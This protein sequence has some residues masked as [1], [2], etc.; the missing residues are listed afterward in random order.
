MSTPMKIERIDRLS[1]RD[2]LESF[3]K[4]GRPVVL[5]GLVEQW[6]VAKWDLSYLRG[7]LGQTPMRYERWEGA[8][9]DPTD[10]LRKTNM[11]R[12]NQMPFADLVDL[13]ERP[14]A[15]TERPYLT[16]YDI[17]K[18]HPGLR[19]DVSPL[20]DWMVGPG[21]LPASLKE[22][23]R[24]GPLLWLGPEGTLSPV[25]FDMLW[26]LFVQVRG[27][28]RF[29]L[30][31]P[32]DAGNLYYPH[33]PFEWAVHFSPVD[34]ESPDLARHPRFSQATPMEVE[35]REGDIL[36]IP[37]LWWHHVR[38]LAPSIS[39]NLWWTASLT[40]LVFS[41]RRAFWF[42]YPRMRRYQRRFQRLLPRR[43]PVA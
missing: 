3:V 1:P 24:I 11:R 32:E 43:A 23:M 26:N 16:Q 4:P 17:L 7:H 33:R 20:F 41:R 36:F 19:G 29:I 28:K 35:V 39:L 14:D 13:M 21:Y 9:T 10:Y 30:F 25:H 2:F 6:P 22:R 5:Q 42:L 12:V 40:S 15:S 27:S 34:V 8:S 38:S 37:P 18:S 31:S